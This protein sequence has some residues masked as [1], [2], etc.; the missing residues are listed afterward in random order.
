VLLTT[1]LITKI[2]AVVVGWAC[3]LGFPAIEWFRLSLPSLSLVALQSC[4]L[5]PATTTLYSCVFEYSILVFSW[6]KL[7]LLSFSWA[8]ALFLST[9]PWFSYT[10]SFMREG[11][12]KAL[13]FAGCI[14]CFVPSTHRNLSLFCCWLLAPAAGNAVTHLLHFIN[15]LFIGFFIVISELFPI[16]LWG[17]YCWTHEPTSAL[18]LPQKA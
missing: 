9:Y 14:S 3:W 1:S 12:F 4:C 15:W 11:C 18:T 8:P 10:C 13:W 7:L 16:F 17:Y 6:E 2:W 5:L